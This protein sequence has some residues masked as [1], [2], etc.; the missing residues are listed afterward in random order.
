V[1]IHVVTPAPAGSHHG[2]RTTAV[3][4]EKLLNELGHEVNVAQEWNGEECDLVVALHARRSYPSI[5]RFRRARASAPLVVALTGTDLY[6][7]LETSVEARTSLEFASRLV[8]LQPLGIEALPQHAR[9]KA[10]VIYQSAEPPPHSEPPEPQTFQVCVLAHLRPVKDPLR[11]AFAAR[12]LPVSSSIHVAHAGAAM[13]PEMAEEAQ[14]EQRRN[15]RY[16]W[17]GDLPRAEALQLLARSRLLALTS[18]LEGGANVVTEAVA[19]SVPVIAS[20]IAGSLGLLG[21]DY[22]GYFPVGDTQALAALLLR[23]EQ[24]AAFY[25][26]LAERCEALKPL[27]DPARERASWKSLL[28]ELH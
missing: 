4:W 5:E 26:E 12:A 9:S 21:A 1:K 13:S 2:N 20:R 10:R 23:A 6:A 27:V 16:R 7:D 28:A 15:P 25:R 19:A 14:A 22:P 8:V 17:L 3:R 24:D 11:T 18:K